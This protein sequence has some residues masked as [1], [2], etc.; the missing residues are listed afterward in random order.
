MKLFSIIVIPL[1]ILFVVFY[2]Y[3]KKVDVYSSFLEGAKEGMKIVYNIF[4]AVLAMVFAVNIFLDKDAV[5]SAD[6]LG[7]N[8]LHISQNIIDF[9]HIDNSLVRIA[10]EFRARELFCHGRYILRG[11]FLSGDLRHAG[12]FKVL[13]PAGQGIIGPPE[14]EVQCPVSGLDGKRGELLAL[15]HIQP[16]HKAVQLH[17][18]EAPGIRHF[19]QHIRYGPGYQHAHVDLLPLREAG[20]NY[21]EFK[22][23][24]KDGGFFLCHWD[25]T[26]ET[27]AKIKEETQATI[28]C[29]PFAYE[30][31]PGIDMVSGKPAVARVIIARSY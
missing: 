31:T 4:P 24:V 11:F 5:G 1:F 29:V 26:A 28:R 2:G 22:E 9:G 30:Q 23:R 15:A 6:V 8:Y 10:A 14:G 17:I 19:P 3:I 12:Q 16:I 13:F 27:E 21:E 18:A 20:D 7:Y 25:G